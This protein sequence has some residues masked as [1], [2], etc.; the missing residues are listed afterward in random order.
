MK[1]RQLP[2]IEI[3]AE[4]PIG[5]ITLDSP[6]RHN[7]LSKEMADFI[8]EALNRVKRTA[9]AWSSYARGLVR[10]CPP[11]ATTSRSYRKVSATRSAGMIRCPISSAPS[12]NARA[13]ACHG[14]GQ[15]VGRGVRAGLRLRSYSNRSFRVLCRDASAPWR[16]LRVGDVYVHECVFVRIVERDVLH[17]QAHERRMRL[18][19]GNC[20]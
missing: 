12:R 6:Q 4:L 20:Q 5:T 8:V 9:F 11:P 7:A 2:L 17:G 3:A 15:C 13:G 1:P 18:T 14:R 10:R 19:P 16:A